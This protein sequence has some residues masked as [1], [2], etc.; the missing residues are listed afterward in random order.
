LSAKR[1]I[2]FVEPFIT[3]P[4]PGAENISMSPESVSLIKEELSG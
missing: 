4:T 1:E 2:V 3:I